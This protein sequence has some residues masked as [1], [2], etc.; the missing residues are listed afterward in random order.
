MLSSDIIHK[1]N[2]N[3]M[4][5]LDID[6]KQLETFIGNKFFSKKKIFIILR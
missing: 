1:F 5:N 3:A 2:L 4:K 6:I